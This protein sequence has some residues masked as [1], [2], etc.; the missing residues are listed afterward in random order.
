MRLEGFE[1]LGAGVGADHL[2]VVLNDEP[3][4]GAQY[5]LLVVDEENLARDVA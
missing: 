4:D 5:V 2:Q 3:G 1:P